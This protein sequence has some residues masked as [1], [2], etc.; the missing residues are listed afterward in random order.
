MKLQ[1]YIDTSVVGGYFDE[2]FEEDTKLFFERAFKKDFF[3]HFSDVSEAELSLAPAF[4][5]DLI[6]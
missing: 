1:I 6:R 3:V 5:R 4:V 2:E